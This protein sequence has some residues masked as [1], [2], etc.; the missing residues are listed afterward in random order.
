MSPGVLA[1]FQLRLCCSALPQLPTI[2]VLAGDALPCVPCPTS[3]V[4][5]HCQLQT[6]LWAWLQILRFLQE[7]TEQG[8]PD[9]GLQPLLLF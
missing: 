1:K 7:I 3:Q 6:L 5:L 8:Q 2:A 4:I 9:C